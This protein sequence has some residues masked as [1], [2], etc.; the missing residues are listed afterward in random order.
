MHLYMSLS[1][2]S[3]ASSTST[4]LQEKTS[5]IGP[6]P[7]LRKQGQLLTQIFPNIANPSLRGASG[8]ALVEGVSVVDP[9]RLDCRVVRYPS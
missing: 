6:T 9:Q 8:N 7:I 5:P 2:S 1:K 4:I 3:E